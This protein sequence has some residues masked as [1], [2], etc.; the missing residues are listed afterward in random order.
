M[1]IGLGKIVSQP[2]FVLP[3]DFLLGLGI[4]DL[5]EGAASRANQADIPAMLGF[6]GGA[7][8]NTPG[9]YATSRGG[10]SVHFKYGAIEGPPRQRGSKRVKNDDHAE[11]REHERD[12]GR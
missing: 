1:G 12:E 6:G 3:D 5:A 10:G 8:T 2:F 9:K 11:G 7:H 4:I